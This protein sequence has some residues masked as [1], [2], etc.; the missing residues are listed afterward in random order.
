MKRNLP[1]LHILKETKN[2]ITTIAITIKITIW[3][4]HENNMEGKNIPIEMEE[5]L[6]LID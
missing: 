3:K 1:N 2:T 5:I 4:N 6:D